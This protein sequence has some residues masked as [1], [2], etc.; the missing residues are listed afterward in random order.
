MVEGLIEVGEGVG[1]GKVWMGLVAL[2]AELIVLA[3]LVGV[4]VSEWAGAAI[5]EW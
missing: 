5:A 2:A 1:V 3:W 4:H